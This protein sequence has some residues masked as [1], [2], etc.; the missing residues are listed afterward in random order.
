MKNAIIAALIGALAIGGA[1]GAFAATRTV[2]TEGTV[3][4]RVWRSVSTGNLYL[5]TRPE[6]G[7]GRP[8]TPRSI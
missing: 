1:L 5:S 3:E 8:T 4:V 7:G 6:D 2:Q